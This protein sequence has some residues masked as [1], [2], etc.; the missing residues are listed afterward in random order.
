MARGKIPPFLQ[1]G[2]PPWVDLAVILRAFGF[3]DR[4]EAERIGQQALEA[5]AERA[6]GAVE[7]E[8]ALD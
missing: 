6:K 4:N 2:P 8:E 5:K 1:Q 3:A 7:P